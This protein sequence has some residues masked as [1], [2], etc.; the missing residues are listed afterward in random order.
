MYTTDKYEGMIAETITVQ[1]SNGDPIHTY[2]ARPPV[3]GLS[4]SRLDTPFCPAGTSCTGSSPGSSATTAT[5]PISPDLY[6]REGHG[7]AEDVAAKVRGDGGVSDDQVMG[8]V[9]GAAKY[10]AS[11]PSSNGKVGVFGTCSG[12]RHAFLAGCRLDVVD[13]VVECWGG[14]VVKSQSELTPQQPVA[15]IDYT[16][17]LGSPILGAFRRG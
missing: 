16:A 9:E 6:C 15:P 5:C 13:A 11:L 3:L 14:G 7:T 12:G 4:G 8:D 10:L 1:G 2:F 17:D